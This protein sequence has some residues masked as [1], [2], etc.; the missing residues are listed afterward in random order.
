M[1]D[2]PRVDQL[3]EEISDSGC[4]PE[5]AC[6]DCPEL[7]PEVRRRLLQMRIVEAQ[8]DAL[9]PTTGSDPVSG[10]GSGRDDPDPAADEA[11]DLVGI[12]AASGHDNLLA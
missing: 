6:R 11:M 3:L 1:A 9:F 5:V 8:L 12:D 2:D 4:T 7:L 10:S